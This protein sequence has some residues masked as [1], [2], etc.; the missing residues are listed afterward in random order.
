MTTGQIG[1]DYEVFALEGKYPHGKLKFIGENKN[2]WIEF[3]TIKEHP[4]LDANNEKKKYISVMYIHPDDGKWEG[5]K[6]IGKYF[7][8]RKVFRKDK[9]FKELSDKLSDEGGNL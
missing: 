2:G 9:E 7:S 5:E 3:I 8:S 6:Y 4:G 1:K